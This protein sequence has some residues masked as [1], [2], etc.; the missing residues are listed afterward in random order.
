MR[1]RRRAPAVAGTPPLGGAG[2]FAS[3][4]GAAALAAVAGLVILTAAPPVS[5]SPAVSGLASDYWWAAEQGP[6]TLPAPPGVPAGGLWVSSD[7]TGPQAVSA[8]RFVLPA[9]RTGPVLSLSVRSAQPATGIAGDVVACPTTSS[10]A[11]GPGPGQWS[12]RP[13][14]DCQAG[15][16]AGALSPDGHTLSFSLAAVATGGVVDVVLEPAP[17]GPVGSPTFDV[18]FQPVTADDVSS[19]APPAETP[20][21]APGGPGPSGPAPAD[22]GSVPA[23]SGSTPGAAGVVSPPPAAPVAAGAEPVA[24][25]TPPRPAG[26]GGV[27]PSLAPPASAAPAA[28]SAGSGR[29]G[30]TALAGRSAPAVG[31]LLTTRPWRDRILLGLALVDIAGYLMWNRRPKAPVAQVRIGRPPPLR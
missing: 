25:A 20:G 15:Q 28:S 26:S 6:S 4:A 24:L 2:G 8:V 23:S 27:S 19:S 17:P 29:D 10:W 11:P 16:V 1:R 21:A 3:V 12:A 9:G 18:A 14:A 31:P 22:T 30:G 5:A 7:P 13:A